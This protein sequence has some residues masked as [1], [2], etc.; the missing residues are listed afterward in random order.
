LGPFVAAIEGVL[1]P[2]GE[3]NRV[4]NDSQIALAAR[5]Q[6]TDLP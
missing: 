5:L 1:A 4:A 3:P 2:D 6:F